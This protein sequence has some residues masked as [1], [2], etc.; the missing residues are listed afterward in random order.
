MSLGARFT[1]W[2]LGLFI[3]GVFSSFGIIA[4][5]CVGARWPA[6]A[7]FLQN[8]TLWYRCPWTLS[9]AALQAGGLGMVAMGVAAWSRHV[10]PQ[11]RPHRRT[12]PLLCGCASLD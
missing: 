5:Y 10:F 12:S 11:E 2:G 3:L 6:G 8:I 9:V 7:V 1:K 4:H